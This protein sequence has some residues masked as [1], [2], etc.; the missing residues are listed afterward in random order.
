MKKKSHFILSHRN[1]LTKLIQI[2]KISVL[3]L[4]MGTL[5]VS[6]SVYSQATKINMVVKK[7]TVRQVL[8]E[9]EKTTRFKFF[10]LNEQ[11]DENR[12]IDLTAKDETVE[13]ILDQIFDKKSVNY[14]VFDDNLVVLSPV[15]AT[16]Q[17]FKISGTVT[18]ADT[19]E[20]L[21][22]VNI[23]ID[24]TSQ[25]TISDVNGNYSLEVPSVNA[26]LVFSY[27]GYSTTRITFTN[28]ETIN[29][30]LLSDFKSINEIV[31]TALG[32]KREEK[33]LTYSAQK[34]TGDE[35]SRVKDA[36]FANNLSG[37]I[38]GLQINKSTSGAG[39]STKVILRGNKSLN[40][41]SQPLY[42]I[43]GVPM[44]NNTTTQPT[45]VYGNRDAGDGLSQINPDDIENI[46]V[47]KGATAAALYGSQGA[48]GVIVIT[49]KKGVDGGTRIEFSSNATFE[50]P[51]ILPELQWQYGQTATNSTDSWGNKGKFKNHIDDFYQT[52]STFINTI[53]ITSGNE[54]MQNYFSFSNTR[55]DGI[56]PTNSYAKNN[57]TFNQ[58]TNFFNN[59]VKVEA[60]INLA[61]Q[62]IKNAPYMG[63]YFNPLTGLYLFPRGLSFSDY[64]NEYEVF[65][66][67]RNLYAQ[68]WFVD[69]DLQQNPYWILNRNKSE[70]ITKR[71]IG[72]LKAKWDILEGLN[73]QV[74]GN[75]DYTHKL[76]EHKV[77]ATTTAVLA[78][79]T[80]R[81]QYEN[82]AHTSIYGDAILNYRKSLGEKFDL[83]VVLG[84][85]YQKQ[86]AGDGI[87]VDSDKDGLWVTNVFSVNNV[88]TSSGTRIENVLSSRVVK[89]SVFGNM[90]LG[91]KKMLYLDVTGRNDWSSALSFTSNPSYFYPSVGLTAIVSEMVQLPSVFSFLKLRTAYSVVGNDVPAFLTNPVT[92]ISS[93]TGQ[94]PVTTKPFTE[95]K[96]ESQRN[97]EFGCDIRM[98]GGRVGLD[99]TY[100]KI[101]NKD[102][103]IRLEAPASSQY[104]YFY[105]N[106]GHI[107]NKG[108]ETTL[109]LY[110]VRNSKY[111]WNSAINYSYNKNEIIELHE[112]LPSEKVSYTQQNGYALFLERGGSFGDL[113]AQGFQ[114][115]S[116]GNY[117]T[118]NL[119]VPIKSND[120]E[121]V[122]NCNPQWLMS[123][124]NTFTYGRLQFSFLIDGKFDFKV[125]SLTDMYLDAYGVSQRSADARNNM[126]V[127]IPGSDTKVDAKSYYT[128]TAGK[129]GAAINYVYDG[130]N[131]RLRQAAISYNFNLKRLLVQNAT[132][133]IVA[134]NLFFIYK[135]APFDPDNTYSVSQEM[136]G[137]EFFTLPSTRSVGMNLK[138]TF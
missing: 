59:K 86:I 48:N 29:V 83:D 2:M 54:K 88:N 4:L 99:A 18:D 42:V 115:D 129:D 102:Q 39:G 60:N 87:T 65:N 89:Q 125:I 101:D 119:G 123:W 40:G 85:S 27:L 128:M 52:G 28:Q 13:E 103:F 45:D 124:N 106:A 66:E 36:N 55:S 130:T 74:R 68:N 97:F 56:M 37:K 51:L 120:Y 138:L 105:V 127:L 108:L 57:L 79:E 114:K 22:G 135:K 81:Y 38:S 21:I 100:Y 75:Y 20:S 109:D 133:S 136:Q 71:L 35:L 3:L 117:V 23:I 50:R 93:K 34:V 137:V 94:I 30:R 116:Q 110:P 80:G 113:Y 61:S 132:V 70:D 15:V 90:Q 14:K 6:A 98:F 111:S 107:Q 9:I 12:V 67:D 76:F 47:L 69:Q 95:L 82:L 19:G 92:S 32:I 17:K 26:V 43:D 11:I 78:H 31:V 5:T 33:T 84:S 49:T 10:Y 62:K 126:G 91:Y 72:T 96:P 58:A 41:L 46:T 53:S 64:R 8:D 122:G 131:V 16:Q 63:Y 118:N 121:K 77:Y 25:G 7:V 73:V 134:N 104:K 44:V 112:K 24:G 1:E